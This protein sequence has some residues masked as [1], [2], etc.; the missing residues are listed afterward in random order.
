MPEGEVDPRLVPGEDHL[1]PPGPATPEGI[2]GETLDRAHVVLALARAALVRPGEVGEEMR[3]QVEE[4]EVPRRF[5]AHRP[6]PVEALFVVDGGGAVVAVARVEGEAGE[7]GNG[8]EGD[9]P[10]KQSSRGRVRR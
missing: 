9:P 7:F 6:A 10:P 5:L 8:S 4:E 3:P 2:D 1:R